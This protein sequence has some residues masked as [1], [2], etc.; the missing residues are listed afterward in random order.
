ML[1]SVW[2]KYGIFIVLGMFIVT[3]TVISD[4]FMTANNLLNLGRQISVLSLISLALL[5]VLV[6]GNVDLT[7]GATVGLVGAVVAKAALAW[8]L[9]LALATG[10]AA[11]LLVGG[12]NGF[13]STRGRDLS[14]IVTLSMMTIIQGLTLLLTSGNPVFG[15]PKS[16]AALGRGELWNLPVPLL[17][18]ALAALLVYIFLKHTKIGRELY[19]VGGNAEAA[20]LSGIAVKRR[21]ALAFLVSATLSAVGALVLLGRVSVAQ[22]SAG[23]GMELDAVGAVLIGG[24][25][26]S[27]GSGSVT[28]TLAGVTLLGLISNGINLLGVNPFASYVVKGVVILIAILLD[29]WERSGS[30]E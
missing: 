18:A 3:M 7:V 21:I 9:P 11:A 16:L 5:I 23:I 12:V 1:R 19:S 26:L 24:A 22:P 14:V 15:F 4:S 10:L 27:G 13:L 20:R 25:S 30:A 6:T 8:P 17:V 2:R 28:K 29:Q